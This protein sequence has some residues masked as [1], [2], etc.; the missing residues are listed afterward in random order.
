MTVLA[1]R[2]RLDGLEPDNLLAFLALLGLLRAL[3]AARPAWHPRAA[4]DLTSPPLRP[5]LVLAGPQTREAI[6][7]GIAEGVRKLAATYEFGGLTKLKLSADEARSR[8]SDAARGVKNGN[9]L[10]AP[11]WSALVSDA[12]IRSKA[13]SVERTP[14]CL[15]DVAQTSFLKTLSEVC[16]TDLQP[17][18]GDRGRRFVQAFDRCLFSSWRR[19]DQTPTFRWDPAEDSRHAYRWAAPTDE[20]QGVEHGANMLGAIGL[21]ELTVVPIQQS[22]DVRLHVIGGDTTRGFSFA[23]PIWP[24]PASLSAIRSLLSHPALRTSG[25]LAHLGVDH[26]RITR[27]I[28]PPGSKYLNF[29]PARA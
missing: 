21:P 13:D 18:R 14:F 11:I 22:G 29:T 6:C 17:G 8:L 2:H 15:L 9:H 16:R 25:A 7:D 27:R 3:E 5:V 23:W 26:V 24:D 1:Q 19:E 4:W 12:A 20:K 10:S 28:T